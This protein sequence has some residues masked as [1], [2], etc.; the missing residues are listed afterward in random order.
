MSVRDDD[1][2]FHCVTWSIAAL[3]DGL[4]DVILDD[5]HVQCLTVTADDCNIEV[6]NPSMPSIHSECRTFI[7][8]HTL[9]LNALTFY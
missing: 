5:V 9:T 8:H 1:G 7:R 6:A 4:V 3:I 2:V